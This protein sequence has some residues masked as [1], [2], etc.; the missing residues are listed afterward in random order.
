MLLGDGD[1]SMAKCARSVSEM[2]AMCESLAS[3][4]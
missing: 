4:A 2:L 3:L 1:K